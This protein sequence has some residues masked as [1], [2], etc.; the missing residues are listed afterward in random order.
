MS[1]CH[2]SSVLF[3]PQLIFDHLIGLSSSI[4]V[5]YLVSVLLLLLVLSF[6]L[7]IIRVIWFFVTSNTCYRS[8]Q[9]QHLL[10]FSF[11]KVVVVDVVVFVVEY[12]CLVVIIKI[13]INFEC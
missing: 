4:S 8:H 11:V 9:H 7:F 6:W 1:Y 2:P 5:Y 3:C 12:D 13:P 10:L